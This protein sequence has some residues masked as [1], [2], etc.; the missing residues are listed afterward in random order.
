MDTSVLPVLPQG[1]HAELTDA[2]AKIT[3]REER[4]DDYAGFGQTIGG[5]AIT[6]TYHARVTEGVIARLNSAQRPRTN[7]L[8][9][10]LE[11]ALRQLAPEV[12]ALAVLQA[13]LRGAAGGTGGTTTQR[14]VTFAIGHVLNDEL[15]AHKLLQTDKKLAAR[16]T[17]QAKEA[18]G[19]VSARKARAKKAAEEAGFQMA[20]WS[21][22]LLAHAGNWGLTLLQETMGDVF[23]LSEPEGFKEERVWRIT[24]SG[25]DLAKAAVQEAVLKSPV[26][27]PRTE[28]PQDWTHFTMRVA[29]DDRTLDRAPLLRTFHKDVISAAKHAITTG[30]MAP[31]LRALNAM[32]SVPFKLN[33]WVMDVIQQ[34]YDKGVK[35]EGLPFKKK[36]EVPERLSADEFN[37]LPVE[38]RQLRAKTIRG[39]KRANRANDADTVLFTEDMAI[40]ARLA[41]VEQFFTPM[42]W[43]WRTRT[44]SLTRFNFQREDRVR[45]MFLFANGKPIGEQGIWWL[46]AHVANCGAFEK[47]DKKDF[48]ARIA[49]VDDHLTDITNYVLD[50]LA[51]TGWTQAD[52]PF[53]FLAGC[54]ELISAIEQGPTYVTHMP[55]SW[56]GACNG[57]Q[58]LCLMMRDPQGRLVNLTDNAAPLDVYQ[59]V[60]DLAQELI[61]ADLDNNE[62]F[63]KVD[64]DRPERKTVAPISKLAAL[65]LA[66]GVNRKLVKRNVMTFSY[67]SKEFGMGEQQFEDT[68][69]PLEL[70]LLKKEIDRHPFG[71]T[72]D[73][74]RLASRYIAKRVLQAIKEI[75]KLPAE[76][77]SFMQDLAK[78]LAHEGK[79]LRWTTPAGVPC[80]NRYH[81]ST[82]ERVELWCYDKGVKTRT[83]ITVAT[84]YEKPI[85]KEKAAAG[86]APN[87][88]HSMDASHLLLSIGAALDA[89]ITD[90]ATVHDSFGCLA[91]DAGLFVETIRET[92]MRMYTEHDILA[93]LLESARADLTEANHHRLPQLPDKGELNL[94]ELLSAKYAFA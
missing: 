56:D 35:V 52:S 93:E 33:T 71:D 26:Y 79:P 84:G 63:G 34:C 74:W 45:S 7:S 21:N 42:N 28:R 39:L 62:P 82:T 90:F 16:I 53:L 36:L 10:K 9:F 25:M 37:A 49:W 17:K 51:H 31:A 69:V 38:E 61:K 6:N 27:Q 22:S 12:I 24:D 60:A 66:Y 5:M 77:M 20:E 3:K 81:E 54:R 29:E 85:A 15:W 19:S 57:L 75:V 59:V 2:L 94:E 55:T 43:D 44:Y 58:H 92:L 4:A 64:D 91:C 78:A 50:P 40:A 30:K 1:S 88:V 87:V 13:G 76:A 47:V 46:K 68:M 65:A 73:E 70:K 83:R 14:D 41:P 80:I 11:R 67:S 48:A 8:D 18:S 86:I 23:E 72:A 89:G 32:Q